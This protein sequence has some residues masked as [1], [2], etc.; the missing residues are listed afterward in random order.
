MPRRDREELLDGDIDE[1]EDIGYGIRRARRDVSHQYRDSSSLAP[2]QFMERGVYYEH[3]MMS[4]LRAIDVATLASVLLISYNYYKRMISF[5][6]QFGS[7]LTDGIAVVRA[8]ME[9]IKNA[10][11]RLLLLIRWIRSY[12]EIALLYA[13]DLTI[14]IR[15]RNRFH[16]KRFRR[17]NTIT[18]PDCYK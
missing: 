2:L 18:R 15:R 1:Q 11:D 14:C 4:L 17:I 3:A 13:K 6:E 8:K 12:G 7:G 9:N 5:W 10:I 16:S